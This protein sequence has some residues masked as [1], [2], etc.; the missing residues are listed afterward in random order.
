[1]KG[2][3]SFRKILLGSA[4]ALFAAGISFADYNMAGIP[5]S[6]SLRRTIQN[7]WL[8]APVKEVMAKQSVIMQDQAGKNFQVRAEKEGESLV[9][10]VCPESFI[11][12][13]V[14]SGSSI[15]TETRAAFSRY[16][17]GSWMLYRNLTSGKAEKVIILF[18]ENPDVYLQVRPDGNKTVADL[19]V[20]GSYLSRSVPVGIQFDAIYTTSFQTL[21][22]M[23]KRT[24]DWNAA[25]SIPGQ[26]EEIKVMIGAI[27]AALPSMEY[28]EDV[29]YNEIGEPYYIVNGTPY[30][31]EPEDQALNYWRISEPEAAE[32]NGKT[33]VVSGPGFVKWV[34]DGIVRAYS[35]K[36]T[37]ISDLI[38]PTVKFEPYSKAGVKSQGWNLTL[39]L[40]WDRH[41]AA[42]A[43]SARSL[44]N[45]YT[46]VTGGVDVTDRFFV[47][48]ITADSRVATAS[49]YVPNVGY[50][51]ESLRPLLYVLAN[52]E[53]GWFFLGAIRHSSK[54]KVDEAV[55]DG[56]AVFF[57]YITDK[58]KFT[59]SV[60]QNGSEVSLDKFIEDNAGASIHLE[61]VKA[62]G[63][64]D[65]QK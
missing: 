59:C 28:K 31:L 19:V 57:P 32:N 50:K 3:L 18:T 45:N 12:V 41:L 33:L 58:G 54:T 62:S 47:S 44:K 17:C 39:N 4:L 13:N 5:D 38:Q 34:V 35:G 24:M 51:V 27:R 56:N 14:I 53:P 8:K 48:E 16:S 26:Y 11:Q 21:Q 15:E 23:T 42:K 30:L 2:T 55:F 43:L 65:F 25:T 52:R 7:T 29:A 46:Y 64:L 20:Y 49:S 37:R 1:M 22:N 9:V 60:F 36:G 10:T 63:Y 6:T 40:D 61:R